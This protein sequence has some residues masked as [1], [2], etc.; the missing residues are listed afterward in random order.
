MAERADHP[1]LPTIQTLCNCTLQPA[2]YTGEQMLS[3]PHQRWKVTAKQVITYVIEP[4][5]AT[6]AAVQSSVRSAQALNGE[7]SGL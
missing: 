7:L 3:C 2:H 5:T 4:F 1:T 6:E